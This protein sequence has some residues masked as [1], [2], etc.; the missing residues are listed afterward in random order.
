MKRCLSS[1]YAIDTFLRT[2]ES[3]G[4]F[5]SVLNRT[6]VYNREH[7]RKNTK[8]FNHSGRFGIGTCALRPGA[9]DS[10]SAP[11]AKDAGRFDNAHD[12]MLA[13]CGCFVTA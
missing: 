8:D 1:Y 13:H 4:L 10:G 11:P 9:F 12:S 3:G 2:R 5:I 7:Q 6:M